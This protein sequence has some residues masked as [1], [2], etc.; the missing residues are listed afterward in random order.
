MKYIKI[1]ENFLN[2]GILFTIPSGNVYDKASADLYKN[3]TSLDHKDVI[4]K[5]KTRRNLAENENEKKMFQ[6]LIKFHYDQMEKKRTFAKS[7]ESFLKSNVDSLKN[8]K[9]KGSENR[10]QEILLMKLELEIRDKQ[11]NYYLS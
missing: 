4:F 10:R 6:A 5:L 7:E 8:G 1:F 3:F 9:F 11:K 2:E